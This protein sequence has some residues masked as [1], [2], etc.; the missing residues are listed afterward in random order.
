MERKVPVRWWS[1]SWRPGAGSG[2]VVLRGAG[3]ALLPNWSLDWLR[4]KAARSRVPVRIGA[5][6]MQLSLASAIR[7]TMAS[8]RAVGRGFRGSAP[9]V[10]D[11]DFGSIAALREHRLPPSFA[12]CDPLLDMPPRRRPRLMW[13]YFGGPSSGTPLHRDVVAFHAWSVIVS[14]E[15]EWIFYPPETD[16]G[17]NP[18]KFDLFSPGERQRDRRMGRMRWTATVGDGDLIFVPSMWWHQVRNTRPTLAVGGNFI[19]TAIARA[20]AAECRRLDYRHISHQLAL[21]YGPEILLEA[22]AWT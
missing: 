21:S 13:I 11:W 12:R 17:A 1:P 2:P 20:V 16:F 4:R 18:A 7:L 8:R 5:A 10:S 14:G 9:Y 19:N 3:R 6:T 15:K 22:E